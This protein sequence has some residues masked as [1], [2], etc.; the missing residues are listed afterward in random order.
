MGR[1]E[2]ERGKMADAIGA[3]Y[4]TIPAPM[5]HDRARKRDVTTRDVRLTAGLGHADMN[6]CNTRK[7]PRGWNGKTHVTG[8][9]IIVTP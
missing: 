8:K 6:V 2:R 7:L 4:L 3:R 9:A 5:K 1:R